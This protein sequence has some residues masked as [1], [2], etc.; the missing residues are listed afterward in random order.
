MHFDRTYE[1]KH[2]SLASLNTKALYTRLKKAVLN[3]ADDIEPYTTEKK[4]IGFN[5][6]GRRIA[7]FQIHKR[8]VYIWLHL[9]P[10]ELTGQDDIARKYETHCSIK[11]TDEGNLSDVINLI[12]QSNI[13]NKEHT[14]KARRV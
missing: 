12:K 2:L 3:I 8:H 11:M 5:V 10:R 6:S 13:K 9:K 7:I 1:E 14:R 4:Y